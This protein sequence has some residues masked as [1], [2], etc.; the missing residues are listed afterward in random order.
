MGGPPK[1][2][3]VVTQEMLEDNEDLVREYIPDRFMYEIQT[4][5]GENY[6]EEI[7]SDD[8]NLELFGGDV[9]YVFIYAYEMTRIFEIQAGFH[10][11][12]AQAARQSGPCFGIM[13][14]QSAP[15]LEIRSLS[16]QI[17]YKKDGSILCL[18]NVDEIKA[19]HA[20]MLK[21]RQDD[22]ITQADVVKCAHDVEDLFEK[23]SLVSEGRGKNATPSIKAAGK[24]ALDANQRLFGYITY[25][26]QRINTE[27]ATE[28][29]VN[30]DF[31]PFKKVPPKGCPGFRAWKASYCG[32]NPSDIWDGTVDWEQYKPKPK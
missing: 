25:E 30:A 16:D 32:F 9:P 7:S 21:H 29:G 17:M 12:V 6:F 4:V 5:G 20:Q 3:A 14:D 26:I 11:K 18:Y 10:V 2:R 15:E 24:K 28:H 8:K 1:D 31:H 22:V 19:I 23:L 27:L 13:Q